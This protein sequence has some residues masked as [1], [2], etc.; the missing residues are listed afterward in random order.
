[1]GA[2]SH[3]P[4]D[5]D[6]AVDFM[7]ELENA[8]SWETVRAIF[9]AVLAHDTYIELPEGARAYAA[10]ALVTVATGKSDVSAQDIYMTIDAMGPPPDG[11]VAVAKKALRQITRGDSE[12]RELYLDSG[13][14]TEW[15]DTVAAVDA[16]LNP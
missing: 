16:A 14:Y 10:A 15:L 5:N 13:S 1:M 8:P 7:M 6:D 3:G 11:L 2:W 9:D 4:F 12:I